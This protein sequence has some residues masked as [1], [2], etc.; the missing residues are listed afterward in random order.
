MT[1]T[2][3]RNMGNNMYKSY[4]Y[5]EEFHFPTGPHSDIGKKLQI[6]KLYTLSIE[7]ENRFI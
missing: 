3:R 6:V 1:P 5:M 4:P 2:T 7:G